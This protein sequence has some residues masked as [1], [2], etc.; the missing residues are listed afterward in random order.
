[1]PKQDS[2]SNRK[3]YTM[4]NKTT[5]KKHLY[6]SRNNFENIESKSKTLI[7][8]HFSDQLFSG[9]PKGKILPYQRV[10]LHAENVTFF[11]ICPCRHVVKAIFQRY[12]YTTAM[13]FWIF[14]CIHMRPNGLTWRDCFLNTL[15]RKSS[16]TIL[17]HTPTLSD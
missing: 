1:M 6:C 15:N 11:I 5:M 10:I 12:S 8:I 9:Y 7:R 14:E 4:N 17:R 16:K 3:N 13:V 2:I